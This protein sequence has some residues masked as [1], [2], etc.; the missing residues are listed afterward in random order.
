MEFNCVCNVSGTHT[1][2]D[3]VI[4]STKSQNT[5]I[6]A[7][8][9]FIKRRVGQNHI[10]TVYILYIIYG[11]FGREITKYTAIYGVYIQF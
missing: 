6:M 10:Y 8:P 7:N 5:A 2:K 9:A 3:A 11:V 4:N 1:S